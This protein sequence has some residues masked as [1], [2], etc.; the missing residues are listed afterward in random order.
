MR[1]QQVFVFLLLYFCLFVLVNIPI[2]SHDFLPIQD[3]PNHLARMHILANLQNDQYLQRFYQIQ[4]NIIPNLGMDLILPTLTHIFNIYLLGKLMLSLIIFLMTSGCI[5]LSYT[6]FNTLNI[7]SL[8]SFLLLYNLAFI[9]G[10][11]NFLFGIGLALWCITIWI[12]IRKR[13]WWLKVIIFSILYTLLFFT[14]LNAF[15]IAGL[16]IIF[17]ELNYVFKQAKLSLKTSIKEM[18]IILIPLIIPAILYILSPTYSG[19]SYFISDP[20]IKKIYHLLRIS[21]TYDYHQDLITVIFLI[22]IPLLGICFRYF[23]FKKSMGIPLLGLTIIYF[24]LPKALATGAHTDW[25]II[26]PLFALFIASFKIELSNKIVVTLFSCILIILLGIRISL[27]NDIWSDF[28]APANEIIE[29]VKE[30][31]RGSSIFTA[32]AFQDRREVL[33]FI[34]ISNYAI[35][36]KSAFVPTLFATATQQPILLNP[37]Y[38]KIVK[39]NSKSVYVNGQGIDWSTII[40][41]YDYFLLVNTNLFKELPKLPLTKILETNNTILYRRDPNVVGHTKKGKN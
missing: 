10:F 11:M 34:H 36:E 16:V 28:Q 40:K 37:S 32:I 7:W 15:G 29:S 25:R 1:K 24:I 22:L 19:D 9:K 6:L 38:R 8:T 35:I 17:Y 30:I 23:Q 31:D 13:Q 5:F 41:K 33:P 4:W 21:D 14:H 27:I 26:I 39:S 20:F 12:V 3:Y 18:L 2:W